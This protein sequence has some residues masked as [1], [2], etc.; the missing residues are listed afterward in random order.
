MTS[1]PCTLSGQLL[2]AVKKKEN[3]KKLEEQL[4]KLA[5]DRLIQ[6]L[7]NDNDKV[8]FWINIYNATFLILRLEHKMQ[9]PDIYKKRV[10]PIANTHFSLD[11]IEHGILRKC[12]YKYSLGYLMNPFAGKAIRKLKVDR[13]DYRIHFA[14][15]CGAKSCPPIAF[16]KASDLDSQLDLATQSFLEQESDF[17][18]E[19]KVLYTTALFKWFLADFGGK[20]GIHEIYHKHLEK[21][22]KGYKI[23]YKE[24]SWEEDLDNFVS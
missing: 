6:G 7:A 10:F 5:L 9:K 21:S 19:N 18:E 22:L 4:A 12:R 11:D 17:D 3:T 13:I 14:L 20:K 23:K 2:L 16:Y 24:Y 15:N 1:D 8:A